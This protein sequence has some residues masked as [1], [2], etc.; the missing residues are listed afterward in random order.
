[1][2][3]RPESVAS[4]CVGQAS[5]TVV[6]GDGTL[7]SEAV[8]PSTA[9]YT[10]SKFKALA[11]CSTGASTTGASSTETSSTASST[12]M[13]PV[14]DGSTSSSHPAVSSSAAPVPAKR[15][16]KWMRDSLSQRPKLRQSRVSQQ[17]LISFAA[18]SRTE[19]IL[20]RLRARDRPSEPTIG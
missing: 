13:D 7:N 9:G 12:S 16:Q 8:S 19:T 15:V 6:V 3:L 11:V 10:R 4:A 17:L 1:M 14:P 18:T 20:F 2:A 5:C